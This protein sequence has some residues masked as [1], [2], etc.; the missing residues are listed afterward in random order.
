MDRYDVNN[1]KNTNFLCDSFKRQLQ[2]TM[3]SL[4]IIKEGNIY[5]KW[6]VVK[7]ATKMVIETVIGK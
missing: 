3:S 6:I 1:L 7:D 5:I 4:D 2:E